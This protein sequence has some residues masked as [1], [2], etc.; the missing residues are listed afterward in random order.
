MIFPALEELMMQIGS[1]DI[2]EEEEHSA[3][4]TEIEPDEP[5]NLIIPNSSRC[6]SLGGQCDDQGKFLPTQCEEETCWCVDEAGNQLPNTNT[7]QKGQR[8]CGK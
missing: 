1:F 2:E 4:D 8:A 6:Q 5:T 3:K 7:F